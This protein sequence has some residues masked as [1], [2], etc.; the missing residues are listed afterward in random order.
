MGQNPLARLPLLSP[1]AKTLTSLN[2]DSVAGAGALH[3]LRTLTRLQLLALGNLQLREVPAEI[4]RNF[5]Q[6]HTLNLRANGFTSLPMENLR[7]LGNSLEVLDLS[8]NQLAQL[9]FDISQLWRVRVLNLSN[10]RLTELSP[11]VARLSG[12]TSLNLAYNPDLK[13]L[14]SSLSLLKVCMHKHTHKQSHAFI[15]IKRT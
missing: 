4:G 1:L 13:E 10:N 6:L 14:P 8:D 5:T 11:G 2:L 12:L 9:P 15:Y 7:V 3:E